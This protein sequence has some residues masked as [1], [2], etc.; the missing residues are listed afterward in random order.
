MWKLFLKNWEGLTSIGMV[1]RICWV[2]GKETQEK[3]YFICSI[4]AKVNLFAKAVREHWGIE[5]KLHWRL[6][7]IFREDA[8]KIR[9]GNSPAIMTTIRHI[10]MGIFDLDNTISGSLA[11]KRR[12]ATWSDDFR[13][14][15]C[16]WVIILMRSPCYGWCH[17][18]K[19]YS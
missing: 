14:S 9:K 1:E 13:S 7:V 4:S 18:I 3:R 19:L 6:D 15:P 5:N 8:N 16:V 10:C 17:D 12:K 2:N 11:K